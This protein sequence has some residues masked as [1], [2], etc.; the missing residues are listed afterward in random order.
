MNDKKQLTKNPIMDAKQLKKYIELQIRRNI[1]KNK[2]ELLKYILKLKQN[3]YRYILTERDTQE[4]LRLYDT[5]NIKKESPLDIE[6]YSN[7]KINNKNYIVSEKEDRFLKT[8]GNSTEFI[9][10]FKDVQ[11][12]IMAYKQDGTSNAKEVFNK[13]ANTKKEEIKLVPIHEA[14]TQSNI[15]VEMLQKISFFITNMKVNHYEYYVDIENGIFHNK[16][17]NQTFEVRKNEKTNQ[18][19]I[20]S[21][22]ELKYG[23]TNN[24][25]NESEI[26]EKELDEEKR[27][28]EEQVKA[29]VRTR[30]LENINRFD[31]AAFT[32]IGFLI[33]NIIS[34]ILI[35][36]TITIILTNK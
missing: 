23:N 5:L 3:E 7:K 14:I 12:Q 30:K 2:E 19:E 16:I 15:S 17:T 9:K 31:S 10:E 27:Y 4:L 32:K 21:S 22:G 18:Y 11:N 13:L 35:S 33:V 36:T 26:I 8:N 1:F 29:K 24:L 34:F 28:E 20:Y 6:D 25:E